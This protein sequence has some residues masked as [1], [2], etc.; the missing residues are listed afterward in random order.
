MFIPL[1]SII[2]RARNAFG[3]AETFEANVSLG[4]KTRRAYQGSFS[5]P[6]TPSLDTTGILSIF[7]MDRDN[8]N[9]A[10][11]T[12]GLRGLKATIRVSL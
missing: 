2:A 9:F 1:Q 11:S 4:T 10:S 5:L 7:G 6:L 12:E 8:S 3:G